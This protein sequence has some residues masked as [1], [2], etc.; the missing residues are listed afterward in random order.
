MQP[1]VEY[2]LKQSLAGV[3]PRSSPLIEEAFNLGWILRSVEPKLSIHIQ[4]P[5]VSGSE[6]LAISGVECGIA[7]HKTKFPQG[8]RFY[9]DCLREQEARLLEWLVHRF[10]G[11]CWFFTQTFKSYVA[12]GYAQLLK[13]RFLS[14][15][16]QAYSELSRADLL[17]SISST[18]WQQRDVIHFHLLIFGTGLGVLSRKRW[19]HRWQMISGGFA[20]NYQAE[21]KAARY[22]V[23]HQIKDRLDS[24]LDF[25]GSWRGITP[26]RSVGMCC[27]AAKR[28]NRDVLRA[29]HPDL[30]FLRH[31]GFRYSPL[32]YS[33]ANTLVE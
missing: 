18:E 10:S 33:E 17:R 8:H 27:H 28:A 24:N 12:A 14:R 20:A 1:N 31:E 19:E 30:A 15:L 29:V 22:L 6:P 21:L 26:P 7:A 3:K 11:D 13:T 16:K 5:Y 9:Y 2:S 4:P 32:P 23:K 25:G